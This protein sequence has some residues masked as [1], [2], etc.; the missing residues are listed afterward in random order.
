MGTAQR[1]Q[2]LIVRTYVEQL[3]LQ[4][5]CAAMVTV[6]VLCVCVQAAHL[7]PTQLSDKLDMHA[8]NLSIVLAPEKNWRFSNNAICGVR[9][10]CAYCEAGHVGIL[11][12][13][14]HKGGFLY[15]CN[16][17][18]TTKVCVCVRVRRISRP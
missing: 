10:F 11:R 15:Y 17:V 13:Q 12:C 9:I 2:T 8:G 14:L 16:G 4:C 6:I 3:F 18:L 1:H 5:A 7:L